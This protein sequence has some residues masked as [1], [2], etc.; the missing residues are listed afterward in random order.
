MSAF[1]SSGIPTLQPVLLGAQG[2]ARRF[3][4]VMAA[5]I[6]AA[7]VAVLRIE[8][9]GSDR[10]NERLLVAATLGLPLFT[11]LRVAGERRK[12]APGAHAALG[13]TGLF[14]L[15]AVAALWSRWSGPVQLTRYVQLSAAFHLLVAI[16][17]VTRAP[18][19]RGFWQYNRLM[20]ERFLTAIVYTAVLFAG[21]ALALAAVDQLFG[22]DVADTAYFRLWCTIA[23][24]G[25]T[26]IFLAGVPRDLE[27]LE[28]L[29]DYPPGIKI[30]AQYILIPIVAVY[31]VI[32]SLYFAKVLITWEWPSGWIGWLVSGVAVT[33]ILAL[34]LAHP[35]AQEAGNKWVVAYA[36]GFFA[37][38][39][40]S[41]VMLWLAVGQR[42][43][44]YGI[45]ERRYFLIVLSVWLGAIAVEQLLTR[46]RSVRVIPATLCAVALLT[47]AGPW[48]AY[49]VSERSQVRRLAGLLARHGALVEGR[50]RAVE[51]AVPEDDRRE[52]SSVLRYLAETHGTGAIAPWFG[53]SQ[54][55]AEIDT[56]ARGTAPS[57][58]GERRARAITAWLGVDYVGWRPDQYVWFSYVAEL[59][60]PVSVAGYDEL[61]LV[62]H[63]SGAGI[64][65]GFRVRSGRNGRSLD[66]Y[67]DDVRLATFPVDS[68]LLGLRGRGPNRRSDAPVPA[69]LLRLDRESA[70]MVLALQLH[71]VAGH[72]ASDTLV[73]DELTGAML[74][75]RR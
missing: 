24:V 32:L 71:T 43:A 30:F 28:S 2:T 74:V 40:P 29:A 72:W 10:L 53:G 22:V 13:L 54:V 58:E 31:L 70:R 36:R 47:V 67:R 49:R 3:P 20:L 68:L 45:T 63:P 21:L 46:S 42:V 9:V 35:I 14:V 6:L 62:R 16:A 39:L 37:A 41:V 1:F 69:A 52:I 73:V 66:V 23:F 8:E 65:A 11:A 44:Q 7:I 50:A 26:W 27:G 12:L 61:L 18:A 59:P 55:L 64:G 15:G 25:T 19:P 75:G 38:L 33:G 5:A 4:F 60:G 34:L 51:G 56:V 48:G 17:P 57:D